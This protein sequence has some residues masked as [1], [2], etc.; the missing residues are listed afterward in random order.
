MSQVG[1][2]L[3][4]ASNSKG[5]SVPLIVIYLLYVRYLRVNDRNDPSGM[6]LHCAVRS[7]PVRYCTVQCCTSKLAL[8]TVRG[9]VLAVRLS[10]EGVLACAAAKIDPPASRS[11]GEILDCTT[12]E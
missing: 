9:T 12:A 4:L 7:W 6:M 1:Q 10:E 8:Y 2:L 3:A 5:A 11:A